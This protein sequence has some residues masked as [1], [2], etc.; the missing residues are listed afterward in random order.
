M[1]LFT[2]KVTTQ[3]SV[4]TFEVRDWDTRVRGG[5]VDREFGRGAHS[6]LPPEIIT[7]AR[8]NG[9]LVDLVGTRLRFKVRHPQSSYSHPEWVPVT[10]SVVTAVEWNRG[11]HYARVS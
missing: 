6:S 2:V 8:D 4:Y 7:I 3:N 10:T 9:D 1:S 11:L 5:I